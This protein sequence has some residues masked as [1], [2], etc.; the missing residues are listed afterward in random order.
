MLRLD[1]VADRDHTCRAGGHS[2]IVGVTVSSGSP[3]LGQ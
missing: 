3:H 2:N 1:G